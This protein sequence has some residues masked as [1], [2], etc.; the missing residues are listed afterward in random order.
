LLDCVVHYKF[1]YVCIYVLPL[2]LLMADRS[3][4]RS[5]CKDSIQQFEVK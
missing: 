4:W 5:L 3:G 1:M 2:L